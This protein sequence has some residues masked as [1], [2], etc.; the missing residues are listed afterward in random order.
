MAAILT[1]KIWK[2]CSCGDEFYG[3]GGGDLCIKCKRRP[4]ERNKYWKK[5]GKSL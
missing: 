2:L 1:I 4:Y 5:K 3:G